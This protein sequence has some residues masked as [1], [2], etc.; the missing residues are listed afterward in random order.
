[1]PTGSNRHRI[2]EALR[3]SGQPL[4]DDRLSAVAQVNPRQQVNQICR[5]LE[6]EGIVRRYPGP[7]QKLVNE[8]VGA[9]ITFVETASDQRRYPRSVESVDPI[10]ITGE[11]AIESPPGNSRE[12]RDAERVM[13]DLLGLQLGV[14]LDPTRIVVANGTRVELD[15]ADAERTVLVECW[16]H[17]GPPKVAQKHKVLADA[18]KL[19]WIATKIE[20]K[21]RLYLCLGDPLAARPF[22]PASKSW[23]AYALRDLGVT[24][25][26]VDLPSEVRDKVQ[27]AQQRQ[28]R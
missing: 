6:Q 1:M 10:V 24:V 8:L 25:A 23:A 16:A 12:Q 18:L 20:P 5:A 4:D 26:V 2:L 7:D 3:R 28:Y 17:Q 14:A 27:A 15:G 13:L 9:D 11:A 22:L 21:P 19:T